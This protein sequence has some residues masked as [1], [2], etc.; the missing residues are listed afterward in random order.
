MAG[1][2]HRLRPHQECL[3][4]SLPRRAVIVTTRP[5]TS[6]RSSC[7]QVLPAPQ[8]PILPDER[9]KRETVGEI[10]ETVLMVDDVVGQIPKALKDNNISENTIPIF[11]TDNG[12]SPAGGRVDKMAQKGHRANYI[13][14]VGMKV[15]LFGRRDTVSLSPS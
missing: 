14:R 9:F 12:C 4:N 8:H 6:S 7:I 3:P 11:T 5:K 1:R 10:M 13:W 2:C 15:D